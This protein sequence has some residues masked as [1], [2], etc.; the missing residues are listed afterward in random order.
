MTTWCWFWT[1][2]IY[3]YFSQP[4]SFTF[5]QISVSFSSFCFFSSFSSV[6]FKYQSLTPPSPFLLSVNYQS[7]F[8][9]TLITSVVHH[10]KKG[11]HWI[12]LFIAI[13]SVVTEFL[14]Q[15]F[16][17]F[18]FIFLMHKWIVC[19]LKLIENFMLFTSITAS[20]LIFHNAEKIIESNQ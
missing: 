20:I 7:L 6:S 11:N 12:Y 4:F 18:H 1:C 9:S 17:P 3:F 5:H 10:A 13:L 8:I 16:F 15:V 14:F 2:L 19:C